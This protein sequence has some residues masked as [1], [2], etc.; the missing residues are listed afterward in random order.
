MMIIPSGQAGEGGQDLATT[1]QEM[2]DS[3]GLRHGHHPVISTNGQAG[4]G[5]EM[6]VISPS[7]H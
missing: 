7:G 1:D 4:E 2:Q 5:D 3:Q 6:S